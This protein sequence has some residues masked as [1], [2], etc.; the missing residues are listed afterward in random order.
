MRTRIKICGITR[1]QDAFA[2]VDAGADAIGLVFYA[3]SPRN[4]DIPA[5]ATIAAAVPPLVCVVAL[6]LDPDPE[7]VRMVLREVSVDLLQFH[8]Q[9]E[10]DFCAA[11]GRRYI[12]AVPMGDGIDPREWTV[13]HPQAVG[14][15]LDSHAGG[16]AGGTG[17]T[18][19]WGRIPRNLDRPLILAGGL[20][21]AN[22]AAAVA[23]VRPFGVDVSSGV[24]VAPGIKDPA[25]ITAFVEQVRS[26]EHT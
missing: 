13:R 22:A 25:K 8:G 20:K 23:A 3:K 9:E 7:L 17:A 11:F 6:F 24:E 10:P 5:A 15:L 21:P 2:A 16:R 1:A 26:G 12:K 4:L 18:F 19:D 14:F